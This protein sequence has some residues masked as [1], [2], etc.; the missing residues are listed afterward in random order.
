MGKTQKEIIKFVNTTDILTDYYSQQNNKDELF[1]FI[2]DFSKK[3]IKASEII[4]SDM[5]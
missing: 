5:I 1:A 4:K 2:N 3:V